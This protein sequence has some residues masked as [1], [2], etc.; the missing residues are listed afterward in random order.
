MMAVSLC[1]YRSWFEGKGRLSWGFHKENH[2]PCLTVFVCINVRIGTCVHTVNESNI[3]FWGVA[4]S[5]AMHASLVSS[6]IILGD[7]VLSLFPFSRRRNW[8]Q[9]GEITCPRIYSA[10]GRMLNQLPTCNE[11]GAIHKLVW[12]RAGLGYPF[13]TVYI[14]W[15]YDRCCRVNKGL[16]FT[17]VGWG[18]LPVCVHV[19]TYILENDVQRGTQKVEAV[20]WEQHIPAWYPS[21]R[22]G[23]HHLWW[24]VFIRIL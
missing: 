6:P 9:R 17:Q 22:P 18:V 4:R 16:K 14:V 12:E 5:C 11:A 23:F 24:V 8:G 20:P 19:Y 1:G 15:T 13:P 2:D 21:W 7:W 10:R 3:K